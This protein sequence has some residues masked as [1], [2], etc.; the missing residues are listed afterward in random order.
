MEDLIPAH[1]VATYPSR[2][3]SSTTVPQKP[4]IYIL[5]ITDI[6]EYNMLYVFFWVIPRRL[7]FICRRFGTLCLFH[8]HRQVPAYVV[9]YLLGNS[10]ASEFYMPTFRKTL[11][12]L[13]RQVP[14]YEDGT[15]RVFRNV[16]I[17]NSDTGELPIRKHTTYRTRRKF[18]I[19]NTYF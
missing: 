14:A 17:Y 2:T 15:D 9:C 13:H 1:N 16:G 10:P 11:F 18:E 6:T 8:L 5:L 12:H 19:K 4:Q 7:N 3:K